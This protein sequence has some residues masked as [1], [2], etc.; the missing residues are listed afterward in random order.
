[1][2]KAW[3]LNGPSHQIACSEVKLS[4]IVREGANTFTVTVKHFFFFTGMLLFGSSSFCLLYCHTTSRS[5]F[6]MV[7]KLHGIVSYA[8]QLHTHTAQHC[9]TCPV[10]RLQLRRQEWGTE[11]GLWKSHRDHR[12]RLQQQVSAF[13]SELHHVLVYFHVNT[14]LFQIESASQRWVRPVPETNSSQLSTMCFQKCAFL[15]VGV[16]NETVELLRGL[17]DSGLCRRMYCVWRGLL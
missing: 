6:E 16:Y 13:A 17:L 2:H 3:F 9:F 5:K 4:S 14:S 12:S 10:C 15:I 1:M 7:D 8:I 11:E